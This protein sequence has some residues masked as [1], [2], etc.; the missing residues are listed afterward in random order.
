MT[1]AHVVLAASTGR[2][3][4]GLTAP[5]LAA[6]TAVSGVE[7]HVILTGDHL[8]APPDPPPGVIAHMGGGELGGRG[9]AEAAAA[10]RDV[11]AHAAAV[12]EAVRPTAL[13]LAGDRLDLIPVALSSLPYNL[14]LVHVHG[15]ELGQG[16]IDE[17]IRHA[18]T[19]LAH[20]HCVATVDAAARVHRMGEEAWRINVTGGPGLDMLA[21]APTLDDE[22]LRRRLRLDALERLRVV[23][24]HPETNADQPAA[25]VGPVLEALDAAPGPTAL[26][27]PNSD[28]GSGEIRAALRAYAAARPGWVS[29]HDALGAT[30]YA[31]AMR[32][33]VMMIGNSSSGVIEAALFGLPVIDVGKRQEGRAHGANLRRR[34]ADAAAIAACMCELDA[35]TERPAAWRS[36]LYG[37]GRAGPRIAQVALNL[38]PRETLLTKRF[39]EN[40]TATFSAPWIS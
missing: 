10:M 17:R 22:T 30:L 14:P 31:N 8:R 24:L 33:A 20:L 40:E 9:P 36:L 35:V 4:Y 23:T 2:A 11:A 37:D 38:P 39:S 26:T 27:G 7:T 32:R 18:L 6:L 16:V 12:I 5:I 19:K 29:Y 34:P 28:P 21:A 25:V 13:V 3:D 15:G 1:A